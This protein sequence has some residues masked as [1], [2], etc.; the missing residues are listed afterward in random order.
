MTYFEPNV[1]SGSNFVYNWTSDAFNGFLLPDR[2]FGWLANRRADDITNVRI[3]GIRCINVDCDLESVED[4]PISDVPKYW[5]NATSW[6]DGVVPTEGSVEILPGENIVYDLADSPI[7]EVVTVNGRL[8]W[9]DDKEYIPKLNLNAEH[10]F[11]RAGELLIGTVD[12][13]YEAEAQI[14]LYG[15]RAD[16]QV[17][18]SGTVEA[19]NKIIANTG[20]VAFYGQE[21]QRM[22][23]L[24]QPVY[25]G[26]TETLVEAGMTWEA[27]DNVYFA[28]TNLQAYHHEYRVIAEYLPASGKLTVTEPFEFY[29]HGGDSSIGKYGVDMRG[30]VIN[31]TRNVRVVADD[32]NDWGCTILNSDRVEADRSIRVGRMTLDNVEVLRGGQ[33][34][35]YKAGIRF[36]GS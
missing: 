20:L 14:T 30:E 1:G 26:F 9:M 10:I 23:R 6:P 29:H 15:A 25:H 31:L 34:D 28:P 18:M 16:E 13:R 11:V 7:F 27:G 2:E 3:E 33:E 22:S 36:E 4:I 35:T 24:Q 5:S 17:K 21:K 12:A 19:G 8:S 32:D